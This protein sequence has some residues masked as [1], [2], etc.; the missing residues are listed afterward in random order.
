MPIH[1]F[2]EFFFGKNPEPGKCFK[3]YSKKTLELSGVYVYNS[4]KLLS[5][6]TGPF[7]PCEKRVSL[8]KKHPLN[9]LNAIIDPSPIGILIYNSLGNCVAAN[10][11]AAVAVGATKDKLLQQNYHQI[12][13]WKRT[14]LY[15]IALSTMT[16]KTKNH[17]ELPMTT[18]FG[19]TCVLDIHMVPIILE[20]DHHLLAMIEDITQRK[21]KEEELKQLYQDQKNRLQ[22]LHCLNAVAE[23]IRRKTSLKAILEAAVQLIPQGWKYPQ[24]TRA[25]IIFKD[26]TFL[27][28]GFEETGWGLSSEFQAG[29]QQ[30]IIE[31]FCTENPL[32]Q[33]HILLDNIAHMVG[34]AAE[35]EVAVKEKALLEEQ[36]RQA[37]K[38]EAVGR[39][40][41]GVAHDY[42][43]FLSVIMGFA[44]MAMADADPA[45]QLYA[46]LNEIL[47]VEDDETILKLV[48]RILLELG[49]IV[50]SAASPGVA[51]ELARRHREKIHL[52]VTDVI[53]PELNG[54]EL[55]DQ[56]KLLC[57]DLKCMFMSGYT[58]GAL[59][60]HGVLDKGVFFIQKPFSKKQL[61][62]LVRNVLDG[63]QAD[64]G[65]A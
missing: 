61:A 25:R 41:G 56:L 21:H 12:E 4:K 31:V 45:G 1:I 23:S 16:K 42:N 60:H 47:V 50:L 18:T 53:M 8:D 6:K 13:T 26:E 27:S 9:A 43:N 44:E 34:Q 40:A 11:A 32:E 19:K 30:G 2:F 46:D 35:K 17:L 28:P 57:P 49:Y 29:S 14:G 24:F 7:T 54:Q 64:P 37:Q 36:Y 52:V 33:E 10:H 22:E 62:S 5:S 51:L 58:A 55:T 3:E 39:L 65:M 38:M 15:D 48:T 59:A 63:A 20:D